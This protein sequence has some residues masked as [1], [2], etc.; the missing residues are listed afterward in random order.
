MIRQAF[1]AG[2]SSRVHGFLPGRVGFVWLIAGAL[3]GAGLIRADEPPGTSAGRPVAKS[4][5]VDPS[6]G[7]PGGAGPGSSS[8]LWCYLRGRHPESGR[9]NRSAG[10]AG[11]RVSVQRTRIL[12]MKLETE[13]AKYGVMFNAFPTTEQGF[14]ALITGPRHRGR[15]V[16]VPR[17]FP[18]LARSASKGHPPKLLAPLN[19]VD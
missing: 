15:L 9:G 2:L 13:V 6:R 18:L 5:S 7:K 11:A 14:A 16:E 1:S 8:P 19:A 10:G 3:T 17:L 4:A 12:I